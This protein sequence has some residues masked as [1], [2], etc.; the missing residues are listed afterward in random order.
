LLFKFNRRTDVM[1]TPEKDCL[2][3]RMKR[4][5]EDRTRFF[6]P[7]RTW[8]ILR[9]DGKAFHTYTRGCDKPFDYKLMAAMD[10]AA[11]EL[12]KE[13]MGAA[14]AYGQS[15]EYSFLLTDFTTIHTEAWF[16]GNIQKIVSVA[17]STFASTF[18]ASWS[19]LIGAPSP[20]SFDARVF[21]IADPIE[22]ENYFIWRQQDA[23][24]NSIQM[25]AQAHFSPKQLHGVTCAQAQEK[26]FQE[27]GIN[28]NDT[29]VRAKRGR[30]VQKETY[31]FEMAERTRWRVEHEIPTFT[32]Q[33]DY[34]RS[35]IPVR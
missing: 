34:L 28:W 13:M 5:Y 26:L 3:D 14:F 23:V 33:R 21:T 31:Q 27:K 11:C 32:E 25:V 22:V 1:S 35:L 10:N 8:T 16:D 17:A 20:A 29:P 6:L 19:T 2:G 9:L 12:C 18:S 15:D 24:R 4:Q 30:V 7:R